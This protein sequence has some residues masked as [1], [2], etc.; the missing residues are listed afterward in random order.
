[1]TDARKAL[2]P[3][4]EAESQ[5]RLS[6]SGMLPP[7][8]PRGAS[9]PNRAKWR[10]LSPRRPLLRQNPVNAGNPDAG[11]RGDLFARL[12]LASEA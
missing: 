4:Q 6:K 11:L 3:R 8:P 7:N 2:E 9:R 12:A 5:T 10:G 1:M